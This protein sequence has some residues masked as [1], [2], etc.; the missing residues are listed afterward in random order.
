LGPLPVNRQEKPAFAHPKPITDGFSAL[1][2]C[3]EIARRE[4]EAVWFVARR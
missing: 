2:P 3:D 1:P 4:R